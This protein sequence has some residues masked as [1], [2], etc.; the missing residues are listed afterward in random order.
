MF[1][2]LLERVFFFSL[3]NLKASR[4]IPE[5]TSRGPPLRIPHQIH[6]IGRSSHS[7]PTRNQV[8]LSQSQPTASQHDIITVTPPVDGALLI[9][10]L[11][12]FL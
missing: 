5:P 6:R 9:L 8:T 1:L 11:L 2:Y 4:V 10:T 7:V 12:K 3:F